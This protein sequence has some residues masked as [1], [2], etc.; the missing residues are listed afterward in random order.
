MFIKANKSIDAV[1][2]DTGGASYIAKSGIYPVTLKIV[3]VDAASDSDRVALNFNVEDEHG[4]ETTFYG[5]G[6][7]NKD[8]SENFGMK[9]FNQLL[10]I[11]GLDGVDEPEEQVHKLGKEGKETTLQVLTEFE[12]FECM[13]RVQEEYSKWNGDIKKR[14]NIRS[15]YRA[16]GASAE[17]CV[18]EENGEAVEIGTQLEKDKPYAEN[19]TYRDNLDAE[20]VQAWRDSK[21]DNKDSGSAPK[22]KA[23]S[24]AKALFK[25]AK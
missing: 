19:V 7:Y 17:E 11:S 13:I 6:L 24:K 10:V 5:L 14:M 1:K 9:V 22:A 2:P 23:T 21:K 18:L 8:G 4:N 15:F 25:K 16:D 20:Q 3:S 12:D